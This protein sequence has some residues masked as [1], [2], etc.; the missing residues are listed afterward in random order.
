MKTEEKAFTFEEVLKLMELSFVQ[1]IN[2]SIID[3]SDKRTQAKNIFYA[4]CNS[5][6]IKPKD[7]H[8]DFVPGNYLRLLIKD[9]PLPEPELEEPFIENDWPV[10]K[11]VNFNGSWPE[12]NPVANIN[13]EERRELIK[14]VYRVAPQEDKEEILQKVMEH[15]MLPGEYQCGKCS[16]IHKGTNPLFCPKDRI[17]ELGYEF[18]KEPEKNTPVYNN[19]EDN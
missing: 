8:Y 15:K 6:G 18:K 9:K 7:V 16:G 13:E 3:E 19:K 4:L 14:E 2:I 17:S 12:E 11:P 5:Y 1:G 10:E